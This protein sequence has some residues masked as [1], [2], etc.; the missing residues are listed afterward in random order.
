MMPAVS[1]ITT[2]VV[3]VGG[4]HT[5]AIALRK[6]G[7][8]PWPGVQFT[9]ITNLVDTPY[10]GMLPGH[11]AGAYNFDES[12]I[13]LRPLTR[14]ANCRLVMDQAIGLDLV[15]QQVL[16]ADHPPI[17]YDILSIDTGIT[18]AT[19]AVPGAADYTIPAKPVP[20]LL[21]NWQ[22]LLQALEQQPDRPLT[23]GIVGGG[24]GGVE[25]TL[26]MQARIH[27]LLAELGR[28]PENL[29][30]HLFHRDQ[31]LATGRNGS[32]RRRLQRIFQARQIQL[33][34]GETVTAVT[35][36]ADGQ[37]R[38]VHVG[39][40]LVVACDRVFWV[41]HAAA[42]QW[43][44]GGGLSLDA[45][46]F[47]QVRDTL[48][49][50][51]HDNIFA[52]GDVA[53]MIHHPRPKAGVFA[54]RQGP[55][56][57]KNLACY[58]QGKP[59][60]PF[61]P[62]RQFLNLID[63]GNGRAIAS[64]GPFTVESALA[65]YWK[66][67]IDRKFM[68]LFTDFPDMA[69]LP[70]PSP[71]RR[72]V[73]SPPPMPCAGCGSKVGSAALETALA[74]LR[75]EFPPDPTWPHQGEVLVGLE[76]PDDA[77][78]VR[79]PPGKV[80]V[81]TIDYFRAL[82]D[83]PFIFAQICLNH[84]LSDLY[85]MAAEPQSVLALVGVPYATPTKQSDMLYALLHGVYKVL[86]PAQIPLV[87]GHTTEGPELALGF[88]CNGLVDPDKLLRKGGM[89][90]GDR[91]ILTKPLGTGTLFAADMQHRAK[92]RWIEAAIAVML[93]SNRAAAYCL[94][95]HGATACT[96][97]TGFGLAGHLLEMVQASQ[98]QA[99]LDLRALPCLA[100]A[101]ETLAMGIVSSLQAQNTQAI[102]FIQP[103][104]SP[105]EHPDYPLLFDPQTAGGLLAAVPSDRA[106]DCLAALHALGYSHS[107]ILGEVVP[108]EAGGY[109]IAIAHWSD[110]YR[111]CY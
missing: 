37:T 49:T 71:P 72:P 38:Q 66:D 41:T 21:E 85:A 15:N 10:S 77:A 28:P 45:A 42:P 104:P 67:R 94:Q 60:I 105:Q 96:D 19:V 90:P 110:R 8:T 35:L 4:G 24:V 5:H 69:A 33:H 53:T 98:V 59:L 32:T 84:C 99:S 68:A 103:A 87:G 46:G 34:L 27:R 11:I 9:L 97:V 6:L 20:Q 80:M 111:M 12:H 58:L 39:S 36:G 86:A 13:D 18:P 76:T 44:Q 26:N 17:P 54:V 95:A 100:G 30:I 92:G 70:T 40:G 7:M 106:A 89:Q 29:T 57:A 61:R 108:R 62:Q 83:D 22:Q 1:P 63:L 3:L 47:I 75:S 50:C 79:V 107:V 43:L 64:R 82:V 56:L 52:A 93:Q 48:Q 78:V 88:A 55:P 16:C 91:L 109:P 102:R 65:R 14:F 73:A 31:M 23:L 101:Q 51:S 2:D 25:L 74:R 81:H